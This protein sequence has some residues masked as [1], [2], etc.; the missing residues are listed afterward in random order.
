M[1]DIQILKTSYN[2]QRSNLYAYYTNLRTLTFTLFSKFV[3]LSLPQRRPA[4][5]PLSIPPARSP[6]DMCQYDMEN[7]TSV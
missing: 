2:F 1:E 3:S 4:R 6:H 5:I 7:K